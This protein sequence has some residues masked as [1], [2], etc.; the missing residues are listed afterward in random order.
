LKVINPARRWVSLVSTSGGTSAIFASGSALLVAT[1]PN[2]S[3]KSPMRMPL[4]S[5][6]SGR[7]R[8][9]K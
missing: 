3:A 4:L 6:L 7:R 5:L 1:R 9:A 8:N 2:S